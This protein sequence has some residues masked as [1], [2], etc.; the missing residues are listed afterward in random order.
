MASRPAVTS[1][2]T[3][4][5]FGMKMRL[6]APDV[7]ALSGKSIMACEFPVASFA[8]TPATQNADPLS[9]GIQPVELLL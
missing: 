5:E 3:V 4:I 2:D 9:E 6:N 7:G 1:T 8:T